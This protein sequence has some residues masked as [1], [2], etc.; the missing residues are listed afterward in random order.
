MRTRHRWVSVGRKLLQR[1]EHQAE[2][3]WTTHRK[4]K[5]WEHS[6]NRALQ[7]PWWRP[8]GSLRQ[9]VMRQ[10][11]RQGKWTTQMEGEVSQRDT[12]DVESISDGEARH[13]SSPSDPTPREIQDHVLT[14]HACFR[15]WCAACVTG[16]GRAE[17]DIV[18]M[19]TKKMR[20]V[21]KFQYCHGI[22]FFVAKGQNDDVDIEQRR[23]SPVLV[24]PAKGVDFPGCEKVVKTI[25]KDLD[26]LG[27]RRV[28]FRCDNKPSILALLRAVL[29][30]WQWG[31]TRN[32]C[33]GR[34]ADQPRCRKFGKNVIKGMSDRSSWRSSPPPVLKCRRIMTY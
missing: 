23:D 8:G 6:P 15:S 22:N 34:P 18:V 28:V 24:I 27:Y 4:K 16:R 26:S 21:P 25:T 32:V 33:I 11:R 1:A 14:G 9:R 31:S 3:A 17:R 5:C 13:R 7:S 30:A 10:T 19:A 29:L 2:Q 12:D 20:T